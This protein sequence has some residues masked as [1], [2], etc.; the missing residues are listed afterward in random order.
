MILSFILQNG[1]FFLGNIRYMQSLHGTLLHCGLSFLLSICS[2]KLITSTRFRQNLILVFLN[3][4]I[5]HFFICLA[6]A[7]SNSSTFFPSMTSGS[8]FM[9]LPGGSSVKYT[10]PFS[11]RSI[12]TGFFFFPRK[13][14]IIHLLPK[15][16][17]LQL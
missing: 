12:L 14:N 9:P 6:S 1:K 17:I 5:C 2:N 13:A 10:I 15:S 7:I 11:I 3:N 8:L 4:Y 16:G